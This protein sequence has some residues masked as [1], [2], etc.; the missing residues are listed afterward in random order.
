MAEIINECPCCFYVPM[1]H[2]AGFG[3]M[4]DGCTRC[5]LAYAEMRDGWQHG[6]GMRKRCY[7]CGGDSDLGIVQIEVAIAG[8]ARVLVYFCTTCAP[9]TEEQPPNERARL[10]FDAVHVTSLTTDLPACGVGAE[11]GG[12]L[13]EHTRDPAKVSCVTCRD[14]P[15]MRPAPDEPATPGAITVHG[16]VY[17]AGKTFKLGQKLSLSLGGQMGAAILQ[18]AADIEHHNNQLRALGVGSEDI[19]ALAK[20]AKEIAT[21]TCESTGRVCKRQLMA[22]ARG[23]A[24]ADVGAI[25]REEIHP[26]PRAIRGYF[27]AGET[28]KTEQGPAVF[29]GALVGRHFVKGT[30]PGDASCGVKGPA[31]STNH[32]ARVECRLCLAWLRSVPAD[33][34]SLGDLAAHRE[35][36]DLTKL[37]AE[38]SD[39]DDYIRRVG[40]EIAQLMQAQGERTYGVSERNPRYGRRWMVVEEAAPEL[41]RIEGPRVQ[42]KPKC[43]CGGAPAGTTCA[44]WCSAWES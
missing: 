35:S 29:G 40:T 27:R 16:G 19:E 32:L 17:N 6:M 22:I 24:P 33:S 28:A 9:P 7:G 4:R 3:F 13:M 31:M 41:P 36:L 10:A 44:R 1:K 34:Y 11:R 43:D 23:V 8:G 21:V 26:K 15:I 38:S 39:P 12:V 20:E 25:V 5:G 37:W 18:E 14:H 2:E 42:A 30:L